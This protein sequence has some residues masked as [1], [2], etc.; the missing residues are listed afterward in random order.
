MADRDEGLTDRQNLGK[1]I[2][3]VGAGG[4]AVGIIGGFFGIPAGLSNFLTIAGL[5][6]AI[7]G[8]VMWKRS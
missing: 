7:V 6:V 2:A 5:V 8:W 1:K 4:L 3:N